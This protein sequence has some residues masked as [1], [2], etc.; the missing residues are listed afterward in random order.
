MSVM[1]HAVSSDST[2]MA[3]CHARQTIA[4]ADDTR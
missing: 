2:G 3:T 4:V 1:V